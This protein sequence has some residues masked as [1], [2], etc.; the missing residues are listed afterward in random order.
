MELNS[1]TYREILDGLPDGVYFVDA[2]GKITYWSKGAEK[3]TGYARDE[4]LGKSCADNI[5]IHIDSA[6]N[7]L[8]G[9]MC[10]IKQCMLNAEQTRA[11][12][13]LHHKDG[14]RVPV[15]V[16][17]N[18]I[19]N[20]QGMT[21]GAVEVFQDASAHMATMDMVRELREV[22][23]LD[24]LT[25]IPNRRF[26]EAQ[27]QMRL[28][29]LKRYGWK[30]AIM[31]ADIDNLKYINDNYG[32]AA[33]DAALKMVAGTLASNSRSFDIVGRWGGDEFLAILQNISGRRL[34]AVGEKYRILVEK[35]RLFIKSAQIGTT[36]SIGLT[37][38]NETDT[39]E[40]LFKRADELSYRSKSRGRNC[41]SIGAGGRKKPAGKETNKS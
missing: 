16:R 36:I 30:F 29:E 3:I 5:L 38:A 33:G 31:I 25:G 22:A 4:V 8:C 9:G 17:V 34:R 15:H 2:D 1:D 28:D 14:H 21:I 6:G 23:F 27:L 19:S 32:H 18:P 7:S 40:T 12:V 41:V 39:H 26:M 35:S 37:V 20:A 24:A 13:Y 10:P 11:E